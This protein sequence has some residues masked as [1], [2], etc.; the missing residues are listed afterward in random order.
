MIVDLIKNVKIKDRIIDRIVE[1]IKEGTFKN[2]QIWK[3][4]QILFEICKRLKNE[5]SYS[6]HIMAFLNGL[7][8][9]SSLDCERNCFENEISLEENEKNFKTM[10]EEVYIHHLIL[11]EKKE[12]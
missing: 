9:F 12:K 3:N 6:E 8:H 7:N 1:K 2:S 4:A 10:F 11:G 5:Q